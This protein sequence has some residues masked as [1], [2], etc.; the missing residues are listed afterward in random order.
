[1][2]VRCPLLIGIGFFLH[3]AV[4]LRAAYAPIQDPLQNPGFV[5]FYNNEYDPAVEYFEKQVKERPNDPDQYNDLAQALLYRSFFRS[6]T[7]GSDLIA[8]TN[9]FLQRPKIQMSSADQDKFAKCISTALALTQSDLDS[10]AKNLRALY[11]AGVAHGLHANYLFL[12]EKAWIE[13]LKEATAARTAHEQILEIDPHSVDVHLIVGL[14]KY[15]VGALPFYMRIL[16]V[17]G[18]FHGDKEGGIQDLQLVAAKGVQDKYDADILLAAI[19]RREDRPKDALA[20]LKKLALLF[21]RNYLLRFE[22]VEM[23][24]DLGDKTS[25]L[26]VLN[27]MQA[28]IKN[29]AAEYRSVPTGKV[30][31]LK[32]NLYFRYGDLDPALENL[33]NVTQRA[34]TIDRNTAVMAWLRLG[35]V[36]D[37]RGDREKAVSAYRATVRTSPD[38]EAAGEAK[39]YISN[40]YHRKRKAA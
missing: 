20:P 30:D 24:T 13:S 4:C 19:Y 37:L 31:Y 10:N 7:L 14:N 35:Q 25:A 28:S 18:G 29:G 16:G 40:P 34:E 27:E 22:Q 17:I 2:R 11:A 36:Y 5:H 6:G 1:M 12:V 21:P 38:S 9:P 3:F 39:D 32:G 23:Y 8:S 33:K 26:D 15:I